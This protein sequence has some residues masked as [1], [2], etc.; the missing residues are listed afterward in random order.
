ML[1]VTHLV[2][3]C[4]MNPDHLSLGGTASQGRRGTGVRVRSHRPTLV[5]PVWAERGLKV[6]LDMAGV[7]QAGLGA[8]LIR[9]DFACGAGESLQDLHNRMT[10]RFENFPIMCK[11]TF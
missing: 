4:A 9:L 2:D 5:P 3:G 7:G 1:K 11:L 10:H 6:H 8:M